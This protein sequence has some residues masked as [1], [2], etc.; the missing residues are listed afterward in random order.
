MLQATTTI[1]KNIADIAACLALPEN[2]LQEFGYSGGLLGKALFFLYYGAYTEDNTYLRGAG[3]LLNQS[4][5]KLAGPYKGRNYYKEAAELGTFLEYMKTNGLVDDSSGKILSAIDEAQAKGIEE[6][7]T[8]NTFDPQ[9]G[10]LVGGLYFLARSR[11]SEAARCQLE[12]LALALIALSLQDPCGNLYWRSQLFSSGNIYLGISHGMAIIVL[13]LC[14]MCEMDILADRCRETMHKAVSYMLSHQQDYQR[15]GCFF[16]DIVGETPSKTR[17]GL[18]Y[19]D[20]GVGYSLYRA[21]GVLNDD[22]IRQK[23]LQVFDQ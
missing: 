6:A 18:C 21:G 20:M 5:S 7:L 15:D 8:L 9:N 16:P 22:R 4:I 11:S 12:N 1:G 2:Q 14:R 13:Y 10:A 3:K 23:A 19:G 17:L